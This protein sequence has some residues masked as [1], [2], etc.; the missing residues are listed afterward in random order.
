M[1]HYKQPDTLQEAPADDR[2]WEIYAM[3]YARI[4]ERRGHE[5]FMRRDMHDGPMP[6]DFFVWIARS[7]QQTVLIDTGYGHRAGVERG[8]PIDFEPAEGLARMGILPESIRN[9]VLTHLHYDHAGGLDAFPNAHIHVQ[10]IEASYATGR[11]MCN[12]WAR[13]PYDVEDVVHF[14]RRLYGD[15]VIF[16]DGDAELFPGMSVH[17]L[18]GH[19]RGLQGVRLDTARG[20]VL[21]ASDASHFYA[22]YRTA[23]PYSLTMDVDSTLETYR[24]LRVLVPGDDH[25]IPGHDPLVREIYPTISVAG[26][27]VQILHLPPQWPDRNIDPL[28][29]NSQT[30]VDLSERQD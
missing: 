20:P 6:M 14:V 24:R 26:V 12:E 22:N 13:Y 9:I 18:P 8:R 30:P 10:D 2:I 28:P 11:C 5:N 29:L 25:I 27:E 3:R 21:L 23:R 17:L 4:V 16:H 19:S 15:Q 7:N 1:S